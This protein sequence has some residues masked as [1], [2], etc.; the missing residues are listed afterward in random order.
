M[1]ATAL[2]YPIS[3]AHC[4]Y[5]IFHGYKDEIWNFHKVFVVVATGARNQ[6][7]RID[8]KRENSL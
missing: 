3:F 5:T 4:A 1:D 8:E 6:K 2:Y 7:S